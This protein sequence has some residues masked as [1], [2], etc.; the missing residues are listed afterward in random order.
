MVD[1][2]GLTTLVTRPAHQAKLLCELIEK[3]NGHP[4]Q[5]PTLE[6]TDPQDTTPF[7]ET[8][9]RLNQFDLAIF[10]SANAVEKG[11]QFINARGAS[12]ET[13]KIAAVG[14]ST[15]KALAGF[16]QKVDIVPEQSFDS[17]GLLATDALQ[18]VKD[19]KIVIFRGQGGRELLRDTLVDRGAQV[20]Y[21]E[22]Y[23]RIKPE[24]NSRPLVKRLSRG[25][26]DVVVSTSSEGLRN[27]FDMVGSKSHRFLQQCQFVVVSQRLADLAKELGIKPEPIV[28]IKAEDAAI[29]D[30]IANY[31]TTKAQQQSADADELKTGKTQ[32][33]PQQSEIQQGMDAQ[34]PESTSQEESTE[35]R[36]ETGVSEKPTRQLKPSRAGVWLAL[37]ALRVGLGGGG[38]IYWVW[39]QSSRVIAA[40]Q[41]QLQLTRQ[42]LERTNHELNRIRD[43][44]KAL[45]SKLDSTLSD[46]LQQQRDFQNAVGQ[47]QQLNEAVETLSTREGRSHTEWMVAEAEYLLEIANHRVA[48]E[49]DVKTAIAALGAADQRLKETGDPALFT[50][51]QTISDEINSLRSV[52][53]PDINGITFKLTSL[54]N[55]VNTLP[56]IVKSPGYHPEGE[57]F[58]IT[59]TEGW[60]ETMRDVWNDI[61]NLVV[62]RRV[63]Q[64][65]EPLLPPDQRQFLFQNLRLKLEAA[66]VAVLRNDNALL[67]TNLNEVQDWLKTF[68]DQ[69]SA[70]VKNYLTSVAEIESINLK[71]ELPDISK[72]LREIR[73]F[74]AERG[75]NVEGSAAQNK[76]S[77]Q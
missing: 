25:E 43:E 61:K 45:E 35:S 11:M 8:L 63:D 77:T 51:R 32:V 17:E 10:I 60:S 19:K 55:A 59:K 71:P 70:A 48:L 31:G 36:K 27:L 64:P 22:C 69:D 68:F 72:S 16:G 37:L 5:F 34:A 14:S 73:K 33:S 38:A 21:A 13:L 54:A 6:I 62:V 49:R 2:N 12:L 52:D 76:E 44:R 39:S 7:F 4:V 1:L 46:T 15:E 75:L 50:I 47:I 28:T 74:Q 3:H 24:V 20:E 67:K 41:N 42:D 56:L 30:A 53:V 66:R 40:M 65:I 18:D 58:A 26:I 57:S 9:D 23:R 29:V